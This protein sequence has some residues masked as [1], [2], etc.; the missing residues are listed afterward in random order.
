NRSR[1]FPTS[2]FQLGPHIS[3]IGIRTCM[4]SV[5][6]LVTSLSFHGCVGGSIPGV[7]WNLS[8][9]HAQQWRAAMSW[10][11]K[12]RLDGRRRKGTAEP[13]PRQKMKGK[14]GTRKV[15]H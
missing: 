6:Q 10:A 12:I 8:S 5:A 3:V 9:P 2:F 14:H 4:A 1:N 13:L 11:H 7:I 15:G